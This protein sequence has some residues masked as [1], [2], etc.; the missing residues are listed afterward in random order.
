M[1][2]EGRSAACLPA[3]STNGSS[4]GGSGR[5]DNKAMKAVAKSIF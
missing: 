2:K 1:K 4:C 3:I 5:S